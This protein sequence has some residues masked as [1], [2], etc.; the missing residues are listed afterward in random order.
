MGLGAYLIMTKVLQ[1]IQLISAVAVISAILLQQRGTTLGG[2]FGGGGSVY[3]SRRGI[4]KT[5]F[6]S[7]IIFVIIFIAAAIASLVIARLK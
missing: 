4:E 3:R 1:I 7:T 6:I 5:L 2:A